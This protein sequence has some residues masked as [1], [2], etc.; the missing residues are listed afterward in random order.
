MTL[1]NTLRVLRA[2]GIGH[3]V[4]FWRGDGDHD[5]QA[6]DGAEVGKCSRVGVRDTGSGKQERLISAEPRYAQQ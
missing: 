3:V 6:C 1:L 4:C 2:A 5:Y